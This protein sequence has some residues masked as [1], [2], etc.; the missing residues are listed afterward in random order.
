MQVISVS[1]ANCKN[2]YR[3]V[4]HCPV[5]AVKISGGQAEIVEDLCV[6]CGRCV[7]E[8]PQNAKKVKS[9]LEIVKEFIKSKK[10]VIA[11]IA[12]S[13]PAAFDV[14]S[15]YEMYAMLKNLGF[16]RA[17]ETAV[18]AELVSR[19]FRKL[20]EN[21]DVYP[22]ITTACP[23]V[24]NLVEKYYPVL[25]K[26]LA[27]QVSPMVAH[28]RSLKKRFGKDVKVVFIGP[29]VAKKAEARD[30]SVS[31][32]VDAVLTFQELKEWLSEG[33]KASQLESISIGEGL[34]E[35]FEARNYPLPGGLLKTSLIKGD[36][37]SEEVLVADGI[38]ECKELLDAVEKGKVNAKILEMMAC[39]GGCLGGPMMPQE[40]SLYE[41]RAKLLYFIRENLRV[42]NKKVR[43]F[44]FEI[45]LGRTFERKVPNILEP[46]EED[47][48]K[49]LYKIGK[50]SPEKELNCG[51]CGYSSCREKAAAVFRGMA[52]VD[53][54]IP[55]MRSRAESLANL[56][57]DNTPNAVILVDKDLK[58]REINRAGEKM[59]GVEKEEVLGRPL[60]DFMDDR[61][62]AWVLA[63][64]S[65]L[66]SKKENYP[67][68][69][70]TV[71]ESI[72]YIED[73]QLA[74]IIMQDISEQERQRKELERVRE[75]TVK[76]AQEVIN[77]QMRVAQ[78]I[79]GLLGE[80]TAESKVLLLRLIELVKSGGKEL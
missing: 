8:C 9:E 65:S 64:K 11:S 69:F 16:Y 29:C 7:I 66:S 37:L 14:K 36:F 76:K 57:I 45:D 80:T 77:K 79:A 3:C 49:I 47:I 32:D 43:D 17:E 31:G 15:P 24:K 40:S 74:L 34:I 58:V 35:P 38:K 12:P 72:L 5:K 23:V 60:S 59:L 56:I 26:N 73:S 18:G 20:A 46:T 39:S 30:Y 70:T 71:F 28:A 27:P 63:N 62:V 51:A 78:E 75:E 21:S 68:D 13:Y 61:D 52:E 22:I 6:F 53:M 41:R 25:I 42:D 19:E 44:L 1:K 4:R 33:N 50:T 10:R 2:C 67:R 54:C 48:K 55:Y